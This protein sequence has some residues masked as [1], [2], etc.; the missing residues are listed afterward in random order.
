MHVWKRSAYRSPLEIYLM[1]A[2]GLEVS[3]IIGAFRRSIGVHDRYGFSPIEP[4]R[5]K[6]GRQLLTGH[7]QPS[8]RI[9]RAL[10]LIY[11]EDGAKHRRHRFKNRYRSGANVFEERF[12]TVD[13]FVVEYLDAPSNQKA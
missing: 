9:E 11:L 5:D 7:H 3:D 12:R 8:K 1:P 6:I 4:G 2:D 10:R 13:G